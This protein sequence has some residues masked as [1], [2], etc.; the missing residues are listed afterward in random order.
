[1]YAVQTYEDFQNTVGAV[2]VIT[3]RKVEHSRELKFQIIHRSIRTLKTIS[4]TSTP[5]SAIDLLPS[6]SLLFLLQHSS[7]HII[8]YLKGFSS[9]F[10]LK[11]IQPNE[12]GKQLEPKVK[13]ESYCTHR[14][15]ANT[16]MIHNFV[17]DEKFLLQ[18]FMENKRIVPKNAY[19]YSYS[20]TILH[21]HG[22]CKLS[23]YNGQVK[24]S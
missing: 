6:N 9:Q 20:I 14:K 24:L 18:Q 13:L 1:M 17:A 3:A 21:L 4:T 19:S 8:Q 15:E 10:P 12:S 2:S 23:N 16:Q 11:S 22:R 5:K 7:F